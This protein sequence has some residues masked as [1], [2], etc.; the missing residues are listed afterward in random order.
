[1]SIWKIKRNI[2]FNKDRLV[3]KGRYPLLISITFSGVQS[4]IVHF[5][6]PSSPEW[7]NSWPF[8][9]SSSLEI[10]RVYYV[11]MRRINY[12]SCKVRIPTALLRNN[13]THPKFEVSHSVTPL[14]LVVFRTLIIVIQ[15]SSFRRQRTTLNFLSH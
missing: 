6:V 2:H 8:T 7:A 11:N 13:F 3:P 4:V 10:V 12:F 9:S 5:M 14:C 15:I 1:M